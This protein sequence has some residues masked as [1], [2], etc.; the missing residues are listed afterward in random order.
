MMRVRF[1]SSAPRETPAPGLGEALWWEFV[2][3]DKL[4]IDIDGAFDDTMSTIR[5]GLNAT[6]CPVTV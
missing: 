4:E 2:L 5:T 6:I 3:A 1:S